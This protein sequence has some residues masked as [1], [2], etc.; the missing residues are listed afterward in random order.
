MSAGE[1][2]RIFFEIDNVLTEMLTVRQ[3]AYHLQYSV[4]TIQQ[5]IGVGKL[6]AINVDNRNWIPK[7]EIDRIKARDN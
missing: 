5:W 3:A 6:I 1:G 2:T 4:R 7:T